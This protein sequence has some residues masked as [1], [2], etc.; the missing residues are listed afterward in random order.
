MGWDEV[1]FVRRW[2]R[3]RGKGLGM[4]DRCMCVCLVKIVIKEQGPYI[5]DLGR[6]M[7][8]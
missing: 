2:D 8:Y 5:N 4:L 1:A 6:I 7:C 3:E